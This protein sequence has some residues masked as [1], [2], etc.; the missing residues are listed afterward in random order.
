MCSFPKNPCTLGIWISC[1]WYGNVLIFTVEKVKIT[2]AITIR[3]QCSAVGAG[4]MVSD[5]MKRL[6]LLTHTEKL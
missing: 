1:L 3:L 4:T 6:A 5:Y 2:F